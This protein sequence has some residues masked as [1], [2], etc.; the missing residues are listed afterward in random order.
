[1]L[2]I[3]VIGQL[4]TRPSCHEFWHRP[5]GEIYA[6]DP[7]QTRVTIITPRGMQFWRQFNLNCNI[8]RELWAN[9]YHENRYSHFWKL[10]PWKLSP[11]R[12]PDFH[13]LFVHSHPARVTRLS[14]LFVFFHRTSCAVA[15]VK[16]DSDVDL[17]S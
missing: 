10:L 4:P 15:A 2:F 14:R 9:V 12:C 16:V 6:N 3:V 11:S 8:K 7:S 5:P 13:I 17:S 1:M